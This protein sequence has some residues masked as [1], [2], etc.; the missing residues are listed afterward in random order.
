MEGGRKILS[1]GVDIESVDRFKE[2]DKNGSF[3]KR[4]FTNK[5]LEYCFSFTDFAQHLAVRYSGKEA[6]VKALR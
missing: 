2:H 3:L 4:I 1:I 6:V 5:E